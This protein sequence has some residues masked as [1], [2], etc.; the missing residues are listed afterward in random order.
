M[1][2][3][4]FTPD[5]NVGWEEAN[6]PPS[7]TQPLEGGDGERRGEHKGNSMCLTALQASSRLT[8]PS[9]VS[10]SVGREQCLL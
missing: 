9:E 10:H 3:R 5:P 1:L 2:K 8:G 4:L 7:G 6:R